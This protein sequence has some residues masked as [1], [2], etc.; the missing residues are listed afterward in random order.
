MK[1]WENPQLGELAME[2]TQTETCYCEAGEIAAGETNTFKH[3]CG[4][5]HCPGHPC[6][7]KPTPNP[8]P[9]PVS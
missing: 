4:H 5:P 6:P 9:T 1:K 2:E 7:P 3:G 8:D